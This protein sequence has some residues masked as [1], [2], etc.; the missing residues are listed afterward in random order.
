M[1]I[2]QRAARNLSW[3][4]RERVGARRKAERE[5]M[6]AAKRAVAIASR[7]TNELPHALREYAAACAIT[8]RNSKAKK[9][10]QSS[11]A[12]ARRQKASLELAKND[13]S[14][15]RVCERAWLED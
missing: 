14:A 8:G 1:A 15:G 6:R 10:F 4:R 9:S 13:C 3:H 2:A 7:F 11:I 12:E 5:L